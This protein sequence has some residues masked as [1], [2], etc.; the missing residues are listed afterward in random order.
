MLKQ[1]IIPNMSIRYTC[2]LLFLFIFSMAQASIYCPPD[3]TLF[4]HDDIHNLQVTGKATVI[5]YPAFMVRYH[6]IPF[7]NQCNIG[8]IQRIWYID[9]NQDRQY[10]NTESS[11]SQTITLLGVESQ[12][13]IVFPADKTYQCKEEIA[14]DKPTWTNGSC[15]VLGYH[16][17]DTVFEIAHDACY[18][19]YRKFTV[20]NWCTY[21]HQ[22]SSGYGKWTHTQI[23][24]VMEN[25]PPT[26]N[27]CTNKVIGVDGD[28][29]ANFTIKNSA[30][31]DAG[32][33]SELLTWAI[34]IDL[35]AD[36]TTDYRYGL[37]ETGIYKL[38][39]VAN[40]K[41]INITLPERIGVGKHKVYWSV[42]DQCGN[43]KTCLTTAETKDL[44]KP[45][46]YIHDFLTSAFQGNVMDLVVPARIF[47]VASFDNCTPSNQLKYSFSAN[48]NDT[49]RIITCENAGFQ[50]FN[51]YITDLQGNQEFIDVY[52]LIFDNGTCNISSGISGKISES[53]ATPIQNAHISLS[54]T[55]MDPIVSNSD[56]NGK[57]KWEDISLYSD[58]SIRP[59]LSTF[60]PN[61][62]DIADIKK[63]QNYIIGTGDLINFEYMAA[64]VNGDNKIRISDIN[65]LKTKI[66]Q[67]ADEGSL[68]WRFAA[69]TDTLLNVNDLKTMSEVFDIMKYD[70]NIDFKAI[71]K[72]DISGAN[73][74]ETESRSIA[75]VY[76]KTHDGSTEFYL[77]ENMEVNGLQIE[78]SIPGLDD[79]ISIHSP[80]FEIPDQ[81][82]NIDKTNN[83][84]RFITLQKFESSVDQPLF[85]VNTVQ[86]RYDDVVLTNFSK[87]LLEG[88][89][90][91]RL[92]IGNKNEENNNF[93][94]S[95]NPGADIFR[96]SDPSL[97]IEYVK[98]INGRSIPF[99]QNR[100]E[101]SIHAPSGIYFV[102]LNH[103]GFLSTKKLMVY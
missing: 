99:T 61:R 14:N 51:I 74:T 68:N 22:S 67:P 25:T 32:C 11:C 66:L 34:E 82:V 47:N 16:V 90:L 94:I 54:R 55:G 52:M 76:T 97:Q 23:I 103:G 85:V 100:G 60:Y 64:D 87:I 33:P 10:Q 93:N 81:S 37:N 29:K 63:L 102:T 91:S 98:D 39:P 40:H 71:Y 45:T 84:I 95:P 6:D 53:N 30:Y 77:S 15:D 7:I 88:D 3:K 79:N 38:V 89:Q 13:N 21:D 49:T 78:L 58:Y 36:G 43:F 73:K 59:E 46:P 57:F 17:D 69:E 4:C 1:K 27:D 96:I 42:K 41:E 2:T 5:N 56:V 20:I 8:T 72:G 18:K 28:C 70:G 80:Y 75:T 9:I 26:I 65:L 24:K 50:F 35:W 101:F 48:T 86:H 44:K 12:I 31:D 83:S 62:I 92:I 19:I